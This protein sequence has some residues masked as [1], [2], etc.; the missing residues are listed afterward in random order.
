[1]QTDEVLQLMID[2]ADRVIRPR[3]RA[4]SGDDVDQKSPG[5][6]V[7]VADREAEELLTAE[8]LAR[9]PGC[10]VVGEE[11]SFAES[12]LLDGLGSVDLAFTVDPVDGTGNFVKGS[13]DYAV[14]IAEVRRNEVTRSWIW[15]PEAGRAYVA[16][17]G[18]GVRCNGELLTRSRTHDPVRVGGTPKV[19]RHFDSSDGFA[20]PAGSNFCAGFDY[21]QLLR[22][23]VDAFVYRWPKPWDHLPGQLMLHELGGTVVQ[24]D[25]QEY[26]PAALGAQA[27]CSATDPEL[28]TAVAARWNPAVNR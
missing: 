22:G 23:E 26:N 3:F 10:L 18:A 28:A 2:V 14:M 16:E 9:N 19:W 12:T 11:A 4:L 15:Q 5:D 8:L 7:T 24:I 21:P 27:I 6:F 20:T 13:P 1:M 17:R 25:G